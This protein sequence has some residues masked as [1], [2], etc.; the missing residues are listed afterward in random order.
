MG[1]GIKNQVPFVWTKDLPKYY[2]LAEALHLEKR[3]VELNLKLKGG[4]HG[5]TSKFL[6]DKATTFTD[7]GSWMAFNVVLDLLIYGIELFPNI[8]EFVDLAAINICLTKNLVPTFLLIL[9]TLSIEGLIRRKEPSYSVS[10]FCID[11]L[12][13]I[14]P[15]KVFSLR[16][17]TI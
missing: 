3:E 5:F 13:R 6:V 16:I 10:L 15:A 14:Y 17:K 1:I 12:F 11:G 8:K 2:I 7:D 4:I 9:T